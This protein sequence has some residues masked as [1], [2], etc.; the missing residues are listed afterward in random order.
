MCDQK[1]IMIDSILD[2]IETR[3]EP[4]ALC[5]VQSAAERDL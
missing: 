4:F 2:D 1:R 5:P 3:V